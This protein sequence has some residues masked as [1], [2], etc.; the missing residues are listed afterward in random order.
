MKM[1]RWMTGKQVAE[2]ESESIRKA[3][4]LDSIK[5]A[6]R[7]CRLRCNQVYRSENSSVIKECDYYDLHGY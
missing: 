4:D 2:R 1:L 6:L 5:S 3:F 7:K